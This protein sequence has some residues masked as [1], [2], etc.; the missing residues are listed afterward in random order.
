MKSTMQEVTLLILRLC[1]IDTDSDIRKIDSPKR[2]P[3]GFRS[4]ILS[5][6]QQGLNAEKKRKWVE[7]MRKAGMRMAPST[8][9]LTHYRPDRTV[10][11]GRIAVRRAICGSK[12]SPEEG[13]S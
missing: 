7:R 3:A 6:V 2:D 11:A 9:I 8:E 10:D 1:S 13:S 4:A 5:C 12:E